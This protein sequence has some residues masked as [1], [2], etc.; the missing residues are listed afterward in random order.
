MKQLTIRIDEKLHYDL[1][2]Y[3]VS[4]KISIVSY[5]LSLIEKDEKE[6]NNVKKM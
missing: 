3:C 2:M 1:K 4:Q 6:R 5:I